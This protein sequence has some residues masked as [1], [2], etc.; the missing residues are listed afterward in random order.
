MN[1][2]PGS[3]SLVYNR[4]DRLAHL[5]IASRVWQTADCRATP[6]SSKVD[7]KAGSRELLS[8]LA[9]SGEPLS[10]NVSFPHGFHHLVPY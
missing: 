4:V 7:P 3:G 10:R 2:V 9:V 5:E 6:P 1:T 8:P